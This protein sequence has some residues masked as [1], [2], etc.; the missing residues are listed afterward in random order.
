M[1]SSSRNRA[2]GA[3]KRFQRDL[4]AARDERRFEVGRPHH[5]GRLDVFLRHGMP[6]ASRGRIRECIAAGRVRIEAGR[7]P[8]PGAVGVARPGTRVRR[9]QVVVVALDAPFLS[10]PEVVA[11]EDVPVVFED[12]VL[13]A[14]SK[15]PAVSLYPSPRHRA[16]CL[17]EQLHRRHRRLGRAGRPPSPCHRLDR[18]TSGL[19][20]FAK[21]REARVELGRQFEA[22]SVAKGYLAWV[23]GLPEN[24]EGR[25]DLPLGPDAASRVHIR[26]APVAAGEGQSA[27]TRWRVLRRVASPP[28]GPARSLLELRPE[29]GRQ[30]QLRVHLAAIGHPILGDRLYLG[31]DRLFLAS[32]ERDLDAEELAELGA[33]RL[34]LHSWRL[35]VR[36]PLTGERL[37]LEAPPW[38][39]LEPASGRRPV[40][41]A[42]GRARDRRGG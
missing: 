28:E 18:E 32:L 1:P 40:L 30:H 14:V 6:W 19:I 34:C 2:A 26:R 9:G 35:A 27:L 24:D 23:L 10:G 12:D 29:T 5:G 36:H 13:L 20:L 3:E 39:D 25:I 22:R 41:A 7:D 17:L 42:A 38:P 33:P 21:E 4:S 11:T 8:Q 15:P 31:G 16:G 37:V